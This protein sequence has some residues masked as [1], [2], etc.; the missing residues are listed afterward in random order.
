MG[1]HSEDFLRTTLAVTNITDMEVGQ[2]VRVIDTHEGIDDTFI[3]TKLRKR[4]PY[5]F[6]EVT[7]DNEPL[8]TENWEISI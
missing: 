6:D 1:R 7:I 2:S 4:F 5:A 3:I 8:E